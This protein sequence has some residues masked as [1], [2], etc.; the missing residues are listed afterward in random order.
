M[1]D[2]NSIPGL[3]TPHTRTNTLDNATRLMTGDN[4]LIRF[5]ACSLIGW[6]IDRA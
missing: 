4:A 5:R 6:P 1:I 3:K 2:N